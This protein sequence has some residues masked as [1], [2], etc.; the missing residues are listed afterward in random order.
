MAQ[1]RSVRVTRDDIGRRLDNFVLNALSGVPRSRVYRMI[2]CGEVRVNSGRASQG[3]RLL[4][5]DIIRIPPFFSER[6]ANRPT[7]INQAL[8]SL[9]EENVLFE[10]EDLL[11]LNKPA[12]IPVHGGSSYRF[13]IIEIV[14]AIRKPSVTLAH[15]LDRGTS[16]CLAIVKSSSLLRQIHAAMREGAVDKEYQGLVKGV[17]RGGAR[18]V[19]GRLK[20]GLL[21]G[22][23]RMVQPVGDGKAAR[24]WMCPVQRFRDAT[25]MRI[26]PYTGRTHQ[27]RVHAASQGHPLAGD[28][29]YGEQLFN[30]RMRSLGLQ[31]LFLHASHLGFR[32]PSPPT[33]HQF[34]APLPPELTRVLERLC[35]DQE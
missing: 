27:I 19:E 7:E 1:S 15:R 14:R 22:G 10:N 23:E 17:W 5:G 20:K 4:Q 31:R 21:R 32:T 9:I 30:R 25:L 28:A 34:D 12:G 33:A 2:R 35:V 3:Y 18:L 8:K 26:R 13:G 24:T 16:G 6:E 11:V 29:K